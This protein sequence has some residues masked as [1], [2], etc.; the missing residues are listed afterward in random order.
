MAEFTS[1]LAPLFNEFVK[2]RTASGFWNNGYERRLIWFDRFCAENYPDQD[3]LSQ[4]MVDDWCA[5]HPNEQLHS[6]ASRIRVIIAL[7]AYLRER[8]R[9]TVKPPSK[10]AGKQP[11]REPH[12]F[13]YDMLDKFFHECDTIYTDTSLIRGC[14]KKFVL[15]AQLACP[16]LFRFLYST[17]MRPGATLKLKR[18]NIN[19]ETGVVEVEEDKG[20]H[21]HRIVLHDSTLDLMRTYDAQ[22]ERRLKP[23]REYFFYSVNGGHLS[24]PWLNQHFRLLWD[25]ANPDHPEMVPMDFR[26]NYI[27]E[28]INSWSG[29]YDALTKMTYLSKSVGHSRVQIT[30][31]YYY[32]LVP[33]L[34]E[35]VEEKCGAAFDA[36]VPEV[37]P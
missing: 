17:G 35:I 16:A 21:Q 24:T 20:M 31:D 22:V 8:Q 32:D 9:T 13:T 28:N 30:L 5:Q 4:E 18:N 15:A 27:T 26:H 10:F 12:P 33:Q 6:A 1:K 11:P 25:R 14:M 19:L 2:F 36:I 34:A 29:N 23:G 3:S 37:L 7:V